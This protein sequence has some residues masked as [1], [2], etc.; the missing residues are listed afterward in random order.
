[1]EL[2]NMNK[3]KVCKKDKIDFNQAQSLS[4]AQ[5]KKKSSKKTA[6]KSTFSDQLMLRINGPQNE[7]FIL[8]VV[9]T[10]HWTP[11]TGH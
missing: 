2:I 9:Q 7:S 11:E 1:M 8:S 4:K 5:L 10:G 6:C 3:K